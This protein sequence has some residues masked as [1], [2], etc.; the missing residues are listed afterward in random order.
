MA[1]NTSVYSYEA[2]RKKYRDF[3]EKEHSTIDIDINTIIDNI[4]GNFMPT[5]L[6]LR[7]RWTNS[8]KYTSKLKQDETLLIKKWEFVQQTSHRDNSRPRWF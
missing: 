6:T 3:T 8:L 5:N 2:A 7:M 1:R 4:M